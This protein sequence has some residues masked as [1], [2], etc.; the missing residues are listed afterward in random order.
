MKELVRLAARVVVGTAVYVSIV[1]LAALLPAAAGLMM[2]FPALNGLAFYFSED[3]RAAPIA[4]SMFLMPV[5]NGVLCA[6]YIVLFLLLAR[7]QEPTS[8][9]RGLL[10]AIVAVW[11]AWVTRRAVRHGIERDGQLALA[12]VSTLAGLLLAAMALVALHQLGVSLPR[13][14]V[15]VPGGI[16]G[17]VGTIESS[18]LKIA[19]F[20][21]TLAIF[22]A[23][24]QYWRIS[25]STRGI[26][27]GLPI[28]PFG[29]LVSVA[30]DASMTAEARTQIF[31]GMAGSIWLGPAVAIWF[32]YGFSRYL[33]ARSKSSS[34]QADALSRFGALLLAW[35]LTFGAIVALAVAIEFAG[36]RADAV[37]AS[38][39]EPSVFSASPVRIGIK[40][41][42]AATK[43]ERH[44]ALTER[45]Q[46]SS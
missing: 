36:A 21:L 13:R 24:I 45:Y 10:A 25:D 15:A 7:T 6:G 34:P 4:R 37:R 18:E 31:L 41:L 22:A 23:A 30:A 1:V 8:L 2:T 39:H 12:A 16:S 26:L 20:A 17:I 5:V 42:L 28:V 9:A 19:A 43:I 46:A 11:F 14:A 32:I 38:S 3:E 35:V 33:G 29:G 40:K 44:T 27:A